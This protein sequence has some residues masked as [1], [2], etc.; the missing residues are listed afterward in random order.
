MG[1]LN[2]ITL[3]SGDLFESEMQTLVNATN[4]EGVMGGGIA[5]AFR[6]RFHDMYVDYRNACLNGWHT[7]DS[8]WLWTLDREPWILNLATKD[9][10]RNDSTIE[11]IKAG[12][13]WVVRHYK[14]EGIES[15]AFP[16]LGCG[17]GGLQWKDVK[18]VMIYFLS[19]LDIPVEIYEPHTLKVTIEPV[20]RT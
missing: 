3:T 15:M 12:L 5:L 7:T 19:K 9:K 18:P 16:A 2:N 14:D 8:P 13:R 11:N 1:S 4:T 6:E 17:L 10:V 20:V